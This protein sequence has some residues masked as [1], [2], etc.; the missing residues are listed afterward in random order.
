MITP[1]NRVNINERISLADYIVKK[2]TSLLYLVNF[3]LT[4]V[5]R[6]RFELYG[7][8]VRTMG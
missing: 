3:L 8:L 2:G 5:A 1:T 4:F 6:F 7:A